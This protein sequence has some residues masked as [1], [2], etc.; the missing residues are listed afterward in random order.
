MYADVMQHNADMV[1]GKSH[2]RLELIVRLDLATK[3]GYQRKNTLLTGGSLF[4]QGEIGNLL[5]RQNM[6]VPFSDSGLLARLIKRVARELLQRL[7]SAKC[8]YGHDS[9]WSAYQAELSLEKLFYGRYT[10][11]F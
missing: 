1:C 5:M 2:A 6:F 9:A 3:D 7:Q 4:N 8:A 10:I 11:F